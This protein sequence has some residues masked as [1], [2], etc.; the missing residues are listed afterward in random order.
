MILSGL[1][2]S[3]AHNMRALENRRDTPIILTKLLTSAAARPSRLLQAYARHGAGASTEFGHHNG[4]HTTHEAPR[5]ARVYEIHTVRGH[6]A[7]H[8]STGC[9][10][11]LLMS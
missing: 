5:Y 8:D 6:S 11:D 10:Y 3:P 7:A 9:L 1:I 2:A 4:S